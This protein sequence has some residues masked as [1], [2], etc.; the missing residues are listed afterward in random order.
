MDILSLNLHLYEV[1]HIKRLNHIPWLPMILF[2]HSPYVFEDEILKRKKLKKTISIPGWYRYGFWTISIFLDIL[3]INLHL[4]EV[5]HIKRLHHISWSPMISFLHSPYGFEDE[6]LK[7]KKLKKPY[8][9]L[10]GIDMFFEP[11]LYPGGKDMFFWIF[12][13]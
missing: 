9:Y 10:A 6:I 11:Y 12:C 13:H 1:H 2:I 7:M 3:S 4:Y 5:H 8:L